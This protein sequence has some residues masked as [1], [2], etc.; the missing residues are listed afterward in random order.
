MSAALRAPVYEIPRYNVVV[1]PPGIDQVANAANTYRQLRGH[2]K[3]L[4]VITRSRVLRDRIS[5]LMPFESRGATVMT[6]VAY[7]KDVWRAVLRT[8]PQLADDYNVDLWEFRQRLRARYVRPLNRR[9]VIVIQG[10][11]LP[12]DF[13]TALRLLGIEASVFIDPTQVVD[14]SGT[15][16]DELL[17]TLNVGSPTVLRDA[18]DGT[19]QVHELLKSLD[20]GYLPTEV[21]RREGPR[22]LLVDHL[23]INE[24]IR[25]IVDHATAHRGARVGVLLPTRELVQVFKD[26]I[27]D[28]FDGTTQWY[29]SDH[30]VPRHASVTSAPGIKVLTWASAVGM[31]FDDVVLAAL[32]QVP[33]QARF[34]DELQVLGPTGRDM[35]VLSYSGVGQ[36]TAL[37][38][39]PSELL[40]DRTRIP[41]ND[42]WRDVGPTT[43]PP[44]RPPVVAER[45]PT[46]GEDPVDIARRLLS[47]PSRNSARDRRVLTA[48]E[49]VGLAQ[50]MRPAG[51]DLAEELPKGFRSTVREHDERARAFDAMVLHNTGLVWACV[52]KYVGAGLDREDLHQHGVLGLMRAIEKWDA[53]RGLKFSTYAITWINQHMSRAV[54]DE[55]TTIRLPVYK[56]DTVRK[57][58]AAREKLLVNNDHVSIAQI[59]QRTGLPAEQVVECLRLAAGVISLDAPVGADGEISFAD[60]MPIPFEHDS[61]PDYVVDRALDAELVRKSLSTLKEREAEVIRLRFGFDG[62][63]D[64]TLDKI[65]ER[66]SFT[67]ER[68]RQIESKAKKKLATTLAQVWVGGSDVELDPATPDRSPARRSPV[69][70]RPPPKKRPLGDELATGLRLAEQ[71]GS[72]GDDCTVT[73]MLIALVD[74]ALRSGAHHIRIRSA[75]SGTTTRL[76][77]LHDGGDFAG[78][79]LLPTL[80][81]NG[82]PTHESATLG[83]AAALYDELTVWNSYASPDCLVLV[84]AA[85]TDTWWLRRASR[86]PPTGLVSESD[87]GSWSIVLFRVPRPQV[88]RARMAT[89]LDRCIR[90]LGVVFGRL[91]VPDISINVDG[92]LVTEQDPF[93]WSN[94]AGQHLGEEHVAVGDFSVVVSPRVLPHPD[95]LRAGDTD[96]VGDPADWQATQGF[97]VRCGGRYLSCGGWLELGEL[98]MAADTA[99]ARVLVEVPPEQLDA[100]GSDR[101]GAHIVPPESLRSRL[102]ALAQIARGKSE[103]VMEQHRTGETT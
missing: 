77:F 62:G 67:R 54:A 9:H 49:E 31:R 8:T 58:R 85:N 43:N 75:G 53:S 48:A 74:H 22:P 92:L 86:T 64:R 94:P 70:H 88:A 42:D 102:A 21:P 71:L 29:L 61:N 45:V 63:E 13:Y 11:Q 34:E 96:S 69:A 2:G 6:Y 81:Q 68:A 3:E 37:R 28:L 18:A 89:I 83:V 20:N 15:A 99:L 93:L 26:G 44:E 23:D 91:L 25:F 103:L 4:H 50:L 41:D 56:Y 10:Q 55:G 59:A 72:T 95:A 46:V 73:S 35:L 57:V 30:Q 33:D 32:D 1:A 97:Y 12:S 14:D 47:T 7:S 52:D 80:S 82:S 51:S 98:G 40:D 101:P 38:S 39:L 87:A 19:A 66:F 79:A 90:E 36:P 100:W 78:S 60:L 24:E 16:L 17:T 76:A 27:A 65:G 5:T 84:S